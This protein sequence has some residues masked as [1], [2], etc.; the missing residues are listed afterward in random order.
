MTNKIKW[1]PFNVQ[2]DGRVT[3]GSDPV[4]DMHITPYISSFIAKENTDPRLQDV[5]GKC[6]AHMEDLLCKAFIQH[7]HTHTH[8]HLQSKDS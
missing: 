6:A 7:T 3:P 5:K 2:L 8:T 1:F 4:V